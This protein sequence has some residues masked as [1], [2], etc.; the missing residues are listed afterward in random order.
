MGTAIRLTPDVPVDLVLAYTAGKPVQGNKGPQVMFSTTD[1]RV[2]FVPPEAGQA[3]ERQLQALGI[4]R[5]ERILVCRERAIDA[6]VATMR[7]N[8]YRAGPPAGEQ[9]DGTFIVPAQPGAPA[10]TPRAIAA[11]PQTPRS[12][13]HG[14]PGPA[15]T[16]ALTPWGIFLLRQTEQLV[17]VYARACQYAREKCGDQVSGEDVRALMLAALAQKGG[18][19]V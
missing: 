11:D 3:I 16:P 15:G 4:R 10:G 18:N 9:A 7:W 12:A 8:V 1:Q 6:G 5:G 19:A 17:E 14:A 13:K 2:L